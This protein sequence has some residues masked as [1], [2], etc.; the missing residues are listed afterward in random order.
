M[1]KD[2]SIIGVDLARQVFQLNGATGTGEAVFRKRLS[3]RQFGEVMEAR[4]PWKP[5]GRRIIGR[6]CCRRLAMMS[7]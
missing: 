7:A 2:V 5:A 3:R 6:G 1:K 4:P